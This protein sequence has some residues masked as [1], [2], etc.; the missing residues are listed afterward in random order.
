MEED[1]NTKYIESSLAAFRVINAFVLQEGAYPAYF[2]KD[3]YSEEEY[4]DSALR[5][6]LRKEFERRLEMLANVHNTY[7]KALYEAMPHIESEYDNIVV[8]SRNM[9]HALKL[10]RDKYDKEFLVIE[11]VMDINKTLKNY[12]VPLQNHGIIQAVES[13][14]Y[15]ELICN[16]GIYYNQAVNVVCNVF[17]LERPW[18]KNRPDVA[19]IPIYNTDEQGSSINET[20]SRIGQESEKTELYGI[21]FSAMVSYLS[22]R[23][24]GPNLE[25]LYSFLI[26]AK[27]INNIDYDFFEKCI[28]HAH[29]L[30]LYN[31]G[32]NVNILY[33]IRRLSDFYGADWLDA[34]CKSIRVDKKRVTQRQPKEKI[35]AEFP[36]LKLQ[37]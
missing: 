12:L 15:Q 26:G 8:N 35:T 25:I 24:D 36:S 11:Y 6:S 30:P 29:F 32:N 2:H 20:E 9:E 21:N 4:E 28:T 34:A 27:V 17:E 5:L 10:F 22:V 13:N 23:D 1:N 19:Q 31:K 33:V 7:V 14:T 18:N 16:I 3:Y 37:K